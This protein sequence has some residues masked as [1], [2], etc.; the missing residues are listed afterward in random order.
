MNA[1]NRKTILNTKALTEKSTL[2]HLAQMGG[3]T[4][5]FM[6]K[7]V[8][9][10]IAIIEAGL[11]RDGVVKIH[12]F[13]TFRLVTAEKSAVPQVVFQPAKNIRELVIRAF[14][15]MV[16][17]GSRVSL[18]VLLE[19]H[20]EVFSPSAVENRVDAESTFE[21]FDITEVLPDL[22]EELPTFAE[23]AA[24][25]AEPA[26]ANAEIEALVE[27]PAR[28]V[29]SNGNPLNGAAPKLTL[30]EPVEA[31]APVVSQSDSAS[32]RPFKKTVIP[33][34]Q[35][36]FVW[37][38]G[39]VAALALL[40]LLL[41]PGRLAEKSE[42]ASESTTPQPTAMTTISNKSDKIT[43]D[44]SP[45]TPLTKAPVKP[46]PFFAGATHRVAHEDN[47]WKI[48]GNYYRNHYLWPNIYRANIDAIK[49][50]NVLERDQQLAVPILYGPSEQLTG[51]DRRN[52][53]E[54]YFLLYR[55][56]KTN[57]PA[58]APFALWAAVRYEARI[59][60]EYAAE[61]RE[62]DRAFLKAHTVPRQ[63][64]ER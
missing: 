46:P 43:N 8:R 20:L 32:D 40:L 55:Y 54:S 56:Y 53:A 50:P 19:K 61:L 2:D 35:R 64:A 41:L 49:N 37:Y 5:T 58:L 31:V 51:E 63:I 4:T 60:L 16:H 44:H 38:A 23:T 14:G 15:P 62:D 6:R 1:S 52:L 59:R 45:D 22:P 24:E 10:T 12:N 21:E 48:S 29:S 42:R 36:R 11:L 25:E 13:G 39:A 7:L 17:T 18:A 28:D 57:D 3:V 33:S 27:N 47:L 9:E 30:D 34:R 26:L